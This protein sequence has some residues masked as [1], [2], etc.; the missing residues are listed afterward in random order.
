M[1]QVIL[2][3]MKNAYFLHM[4]ALSFWCLIFWLLSIKEDE[5]RTE[6]INYRN[7]KMLKKMFK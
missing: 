1:L 2:F 5:I 4:M 6:Y 3:F 7:K